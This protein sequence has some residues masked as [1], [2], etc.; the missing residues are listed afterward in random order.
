MPALVLLGYY[1]LQYQPKQQT[2]DMLLSEI[3]KQENAIRVKE[4]KARRLAVLKAENQ[5]LEARLKDL[6]E[7]LPE[8]KEVSGLLRQISDLGHAAGLEINSWVPKARRPNPS[9]L[10]DEIP[11]EVRVTAGYHALGEFFSSVS[12]MTRIVNVSG[13]TLASDKA[14]FR[15]D[16]SPA[17]SVSFTATTFTATSTAAPQGRKRGGA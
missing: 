3:Q 17:L 4:T 8:E 16:G 9:G 15:P 10:Y 12:A 1:L 7:Q 14:R 13:I 11:V 5:W 2:I 6:Q